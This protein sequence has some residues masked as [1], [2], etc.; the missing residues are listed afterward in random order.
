[1]PKNR[2]GTAV[3]TYG[4]LA[5]LAGSVGLVADTEDGRKA[6]VSWLSTDKKAARKALFTQVAARRTAPAS[7]AQRTANASGGTS[8]GSQYPQ[9]WLAGRRR[10]GRAAVA[11]QG[12]RPQAPPQYPAAWQPTPAKVGVVTEAND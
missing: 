6:F 10:G 1:M 3:T 9:G 8:A 7:A 11:A 5:I 2:R 12:R 4:E